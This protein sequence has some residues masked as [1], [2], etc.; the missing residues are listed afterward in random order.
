M[1]VSADIQRDV[2]ALPAVM[3]LVE[4]FCASHELGAQARYAVELALEEI[5]TNM[6][7]YNAAG[8]GAI[9]IA[10]ADQD[11]DVVVTVTDSDSARFDPFRDAVPADTSAPLSER[12]P[13]GLGIHL[14]RKMMDGI[15]Y[16]HQNRTSTIT[17]RKRKY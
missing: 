14:V 10:L 12:S 6:V 16:S 13:G 15:E 3:R 1:M 17:L 5:F 9:H 11:P 8:A 7:K 2:Q 4:D